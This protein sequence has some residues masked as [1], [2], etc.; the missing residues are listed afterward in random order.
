VKFPDG[1]A[2]NIGRC[3]NK[4]PSKILGMKSHDCHIFLHRLLPIAI[5]G[6]LTTKIRTTL[7]GLSS[8]FKQLCARTLKL[9]VLKQMKDDVVVIL[10]KLEK[11]FPPAFFDI[12][13]HLIVHLP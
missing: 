1:Y 4:L 11:I 13:V 6:Y 10:C 8:F 5:R 12:M 7:I 3:V 2:S 9:D